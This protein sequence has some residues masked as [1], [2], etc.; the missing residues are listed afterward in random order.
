MTR[1]IINVAVI[2]III[3]TTV[4]IITVIIRLCL[5]THQNR[6]T[7]IIT[8]VAAIVT[9]TIIQLKA[10]PLQVLK[11]NNLQVLEPGAVHADHTS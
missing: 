9:T 3:T 1:I 10:M 6:M 5:N 11:Q 2:T 4:I 8:A 7:L